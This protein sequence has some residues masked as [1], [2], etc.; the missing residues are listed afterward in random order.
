VL[1]RSP[2][3]EFWED[4]ISFLAILVFLY[5]LFLAGCGGE[6]DGRICVD[7]DGALCCR[8][9]GTLGPMS[10][11]PRPQPPVLPPPGAR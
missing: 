2:A 6:G 9:A 11:L 8:E 7:R 5:V 4:V 10:C 3:R 1:K